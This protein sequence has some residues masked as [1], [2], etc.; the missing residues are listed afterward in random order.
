MSTASLDVPSASS[1][2]PSPL[3]RSGVLAHHPS[4]G[5]RAMAGEGGG[6]GFP[7]PELMYCPRLQP[8]LTPV[9]YNGQLVSSLFRQLSTTSPPIAERK[10]KF[11]Q[12]LPVY[13][14]YDTTVDSTLF[15]LALYENFDR[16]LLAHYDT[17]GNLMFGLLLYKLHTIDV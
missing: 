15:S 16:P 3:P 12:V 1:S 9:Q 10:R 2:T 11:G 13:I 8:L 17:E 5:G 7:V 4:D 6:G 14:I